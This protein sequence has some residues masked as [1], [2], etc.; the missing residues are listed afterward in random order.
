MEKINSTDLAGKTKQAELKI[1]EGQNELSGV[2][3]T[4]EENTDVLSHEASM[5]YMSKLNAD[6][7]VAVDGGDQTKAQEILKG[8]FDHKESMKKYQA[9][10]RENVGDYID[11][12]G[13]VNNEEFEKQMSAFMRE[14]FAIWYGEK[15]ADKA[16]IKMLSKPLAE[17]NYEEMRKNDPSKFGEYSMN[18]DR[19]GVNYVEKKET[20]KIKILNQEL[21][22][23]IGKPRSEAIKFVVENYGDKFRL[24]DLEDEQY[25]LSLPVDKVP[26]EL[27]D[28]NYFYFM[29]STLRG[30]GG[31]AVVPCVDWDGKKLGRSARTLSDEWNE[32]D[33]VLLLEK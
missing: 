31:R 21:K 23:F 10:A 14:T 30:Q 25:L 16:N 18:P 24:P 19:T 3:K 17:I 32:S 29:G 8:I 1:K 20:P 13:E 33:R 7:K 2:R 6:L 22:Q 12:K 5:D 28:G 11:A 9:L 26:A 27:K 15:D 4:V